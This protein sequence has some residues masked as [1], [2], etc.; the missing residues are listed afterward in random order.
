MVETVSVS[1]LYIRMDGATGDIWS[2]G[3]FSFESPL[4]DLIDR[5]DYTLEELLAEDELLQELRGMHPQL[6]KFLS[7]EEAV[8]GLIKYVIRMETEPLTNG[9]TPQPQEIG[10]PHDED[11]GS[12]KPGQWLFPPMEKPPEAPKKFA[13]EEKELRA[14][15]YPYM[16][17]EVICCEISSIIDMLVDGH[18]AANE[19]QV[20]E[21]NQNHV[22]ATTND[23]RAILDLLF[24]L[25]DT[26]IG[27]LDDYRAGYLDKILSV[28]VRKRP[29]AMSAYINNGGVALMSAMMNHLYS[30]SVMQIVQRLLIMPPPLAAQDDDSNRE[31]DEDEDSL[32]HCRW[33]ELPE[34]VD[35]L[36]DSLIVLDTA[37]ESQSDIQ[38]SK[39]QNASELLITVIQNS[40]LTSPTLLALTTEPI[41]GRIV[42]AACTLDGADFSPHDSSLTCAMNVLESLVLQLGGYGSVGTAATEEEA[43][44]DAN[45][46]EDESL[47][48]GEEKRM[49]KSLHEVANANALILH[50]PELLR[51]L[52]VLLRHPSTKTWLSPMQFSKTDE[53]ALLGM[54]RLRIVRLVE[55]LVLLGNP[56][57]DTL[58]CE[59]DCL[60]ICLDLFWEFQWCSMLHQSVANLLVHVFEGANERADLQEYFL[61]K[62][63]LLRRLMDSFD[64]ERDEATEDEL[65]PDT[66]M[67]M[68]TLRKKNRTL[69]VE[70]VRGSFSSIGGAIDEQDEDVIPVSDDD[71]DAAIEHQAAVTELEG[72][73]QEN[74]TETAE[75][76]SD[77]AVG[78]LLDETK[79]ASDLK[80]SIPSLRMGCLGHVIIICQAL[81][82]ACNND[83]HGESHEEDVNECSETA[84]SVGFGASADANGKE[85]GLSDL[86]KKEDKTEPPSSG[87][88]STV[89]HIEDQEDDKSGRTAT[90]DSQGTVSNDLIIAQLVNSHPLHAR[91]S[92]FI[93]TTLAS[94][95][96]IQSTPLGGTNTAAVDPMQS[97][98]LNASVTRS[99]RSYDFSDDDGEE[100]SGGSARGFLGGEVLDM[101]DNDLDIAASMMEALTLSR[102][103]GAHASGDRD[104]DNVGDSSGLRHDAAVASFGTVIP[105]SGATAGDYIFDDPLGGNSKFNAFGHDDSDDEDPAEKRDTELV[106]EDDGMMPEISGPDDEA[107]APVM[108]LFTGFDQTQANDIAS[109]QGNGENVTWSN[110]ANFDEAFAAASSNENIIFASYSSDEDDGVQMNL[111]VSSDTVELDETNVEDLFGSTPHALLLGDDDADDSQRV[112]TADEQTSDSPDLPKQESESA[113]ADSPFKNPSEEISADLFEPKLESVSG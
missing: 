50:L 20:E 9:S 80:S 63:N 109:G 14:I 15:R 100:A 36:R 27:Q 70:S 38:L 87:I 49:P 61:V 105:H 5:G 29:K 23:R 40:P 6:I 18:L 4:K 32:F 26:S 98:V 73:R 25:L 12:K 82:H 53:Q 60:S 46:E 51:E 71:V 88:S 93:A 30:H 11:D 1:T 66:V 39:A 10:A 84:R 76:D 104:V 95:T 43:S 89:D 37:P 72:E 56:K 19:K 24:S 90:S 55:S 79:D 77:K 96:A 59:S 111:G 41:V 83:M 81:V 68:Q 107:E 34:A 16:A 62:C 103:R 91:W 75:H 3:A 113:L 101:D 85:S 2:T 112:E 97:Q 42:K 110:F 74:N 52:C 31:Y 86:S 92:E 21:D 69:S 102:P 58:L 22:Q 17:C 47:N 45:G 67:A 78:G 28:L 33:S 13:G 8:T 64:D 108:D 7:T 94:E 54:S 99:T 35:L 44:G 106:G 57:V 48:Q 65:M